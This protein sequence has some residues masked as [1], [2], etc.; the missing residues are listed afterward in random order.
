MKQAYIL[1]LPKVNESVRQAVARYNET[2]TTPAQI[3]TV[4]EK[5]TTINTAAQGDIH[6]TI[7]TK[8]QTHIVTALAPY[9][10]DIIGATPIG[11]T[12]VR[13]LTAMSPLLPYVTMPTAS[14]LRW[15][16]DKISMR[17]LFAASDN[18]AITPS[19]MIVEDDS[20]ETV[21]KIIKKVGM[22][23]IVKPSGLAES[24]LV[25]KCYHK[26]ELQ[27]AL[28]HVFKKIKSLK[29]HHK[30]HPDVRVLVEHFMEGDMYS[31]DAYVSKRG[32]ISFCP[33]VYVKTGKQAGYDD[34]F[35]YLQITPA[36]LLEKNVK[37]AQAVAGSAI[38]ALKLR[39]SSAHV[40]LMRTELGWKVIEVGARV[41]G[42]RH[43]LYQLSHG[44][45]HR[46]NDLLVR[47]GKAVTVPKKQI[48]YA[49]AMKIYAKKEGVLKQVKGIRKIKSLASIK[50]IRVA[51]KVGDTCRFAKNGDVPPVTLIV[52]NKDRAALLADIRRIEQNLSFV[53]S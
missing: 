48:G 39:A 37:A 22:P 29:K 8:D 24:L 40:E 10:Q 41:G 31:V 9:A 7:D 4:S 32:K 1:A 23:L 14:S 34:F 13:L 33:M 6:V 53:I 3:I 26:E 20:T 50:K 16:T 35:G 28:K 30:C 11:E 43:D 25:T 45:N 38:R 47:L 12:G 21:E 44:I 18:P 19:F 15:A 5:G 42:F 27:A 46:L 51:K 17:R 49:A 52:A 36:K 2:A